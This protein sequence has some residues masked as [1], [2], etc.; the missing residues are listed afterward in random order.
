[1]YALEGLVYS[2]FCSL[3]KAKGQGKC[4]LWNVHD[5]AQTDDDRWHGHAAHMNMNNGHRQHVAEERRE[6][7]RNDNQNNISLQARPP[8]TT[9]SQKARTTQTPTA[10]MQN[11]EERKPAPEF[12][13]SRSTTSDPPRLHN[14]SAPRPSSIANR[15]RSNNRGSLSSDC[16]T[17]KSGGRVQR[18]EL[19]VGSRRRQQLGCSSIICHPS[20]SACAEE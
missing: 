8:E 7:E 16:K 9:P 11:L 14:T 15:V 17:P 10:P 13:A 18:R 5:D 12:P 3:N 6:R 1:M 4:L 19:K 2:P 20:S